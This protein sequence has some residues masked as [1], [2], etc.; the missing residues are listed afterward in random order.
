[1]NALRIRNDAGPHPNP[2]PAKPG[3]GAARPFP[4]RRWG[5]A[6]MG[7]IDPAALPIP[8]P[9]TQHSMQA[10]QGLPA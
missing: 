6:G 2:V 9:L 3:D 7:A 8:T 10:P 1:M 5:K 4:H